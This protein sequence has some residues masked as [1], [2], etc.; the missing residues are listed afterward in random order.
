[1][2][3]NQAFKKLY[4]DWK[5]CNLH[6]QT[7]R[8]GKSYTLH[9]HTLVSYM[10]IKKIIKICRNAR[11]KVIPSSAFLPLGNR[12]S[13]ALGS[14]LRA[15]WSWNSPKMPSNATVSHTVLFQYSPWTLG[16]RGYYAGYHCSWCF[17][18][19]D[20]QAKLMAAQA[21]DK[22]R[23]HCKHFPQKIVAN[24]FVSQL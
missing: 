21:E 24:L 13:P 12:L 2:P 10:M 11:G 23:Y 1:M 9:F 4:E 5:G 17:S 16:G 18:V 20:I 14:V 8:G 19:P 7:A 6:V 15:R 22:P 3:D